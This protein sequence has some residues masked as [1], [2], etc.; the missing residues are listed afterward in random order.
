MKQATAIALAL[1]RAIG[2]FGQSAVAPA[3]FE[4]ASVKPNNSGDGTSSFH[5]N[6]GN[7]RSSNVSLRDF[8]KWAYRV[9]DYQVLGPNW[10]TSQ[11]Y[12]IVAKAEAP[13]PADRLM[14]MLQ[15]LLAERFKL[16]IHRETR[17]GAGYALVVGK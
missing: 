10:L 5:T 2:A 3:A 13:I 1:F 6:N 9:Q 17:E 4:V 14:A 8:V 12:D 7:L 11:K 15:A 16:A